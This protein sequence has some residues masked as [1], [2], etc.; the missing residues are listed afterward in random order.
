MGTQDNCNSFIHFR[1]LKD[2]LGLFYSP[3]SP[4]SQQ[5]TQSWDSFQLHSQ[6]HVSPALDLLQQSATAGTVMSITNSGNPVWPVACFFVL[7][8]FFNYYYSHRRLLNQ[9]LD[10]SLTSYIH[11]PQ[12]SHLQLI[13]PE[14]FWASNKGPTQPIVQDAIACLSDIWILYDTGKLL[15][16]AYTS[17]SPE[18]N[19]WC[20]H[21][22][23][24][25]TSFLTMTAVM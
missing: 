3:L 24:I 7:F 14:L 8:G 4:P 11:C 5:N 25:P 10:K 23:L 9:I 20:W 6:K 22:I 12:H 1:C 2:R 13:A 19:S 21:C 15:N 17:C 16:G 18:G